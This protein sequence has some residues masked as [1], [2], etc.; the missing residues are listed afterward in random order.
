MLAVNSVSD[1]FF[2]F[3]H[4]IRCL[5]MCWMTGV[6]PSIIVQ[7]FSFLIISLPVLLTALL[8]H[9]TYTLSASSKG[10]L[11]GSP[12]RGG[13]VAVS[14]FDINQPSLPTPFNLFLCLFLSLW[15]FHCISFDKFSRK[16]SDFSLCSSGLLFLPYWSFQPHIS[17]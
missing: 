2:I 1:F 4:L 17:L 13:D 16:L 14:A 6:V 9:L 11:A 10:V 12:S 3:F 8:R 7:I 15:P 5:A